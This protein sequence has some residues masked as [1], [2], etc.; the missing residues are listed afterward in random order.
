[1]K[2]T[3]DL[4]SAVKSL[5]N[6][7]KDKLLLRL[8][9]KDKV[10]IEQLYFQLIEG[11][12]TMLERR[13]LIADTLEDL[14]DTPSLPLHRL[15]LNIR[16]ANRRIQHHIK[17]TKDAYGEVALYMSLLTLLLAYHGSICRNRTYAHRKIL[18]WLDHRIP[19]LEKKYNKLEEDYRLDFATQ[20]HEIQQQYPRI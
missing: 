17:I 7:E 14:M 9:R 10:L 16:E 19:W 1:M 13:R 20:W 3:E 2:L 4:A 15:S 8:I 11:G 6:K 12:E 18:Q 5:P